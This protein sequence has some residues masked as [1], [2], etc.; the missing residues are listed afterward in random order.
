MDA[1]L[2]DTRDG[3]TVCTYLDWPWSPAGVKTND[4][5]GCARAQRAA[6]RENA[7]E[8]TERFVV[9]PVQPRVGQRCKVK[10]YNAIRRGVVTNVK[11]WGRRVRVRVRWHN[12]QGTP[13]EHWYSNLDLRRAET[14]A[15]TT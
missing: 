5:F 15:L 3:T 14:E 9:E 7:S 1:K 12:K 8:A 10:A 6:N 4:R 11:T 2:I 13:H